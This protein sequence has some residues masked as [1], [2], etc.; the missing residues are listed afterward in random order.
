MLEDH[1]LDRSAFHLYTIYNLQEAS[2]TISAPSESVHFV[3]INDYEDDGG[4]LFTKHEPIE[5]ANGKLRSL[6]VMEFSIPELPSGKLLAI[7]ILSTWGDP[8]Y[9]GL[10]GIEIFD[11]FGH[12]VLLSNPEQQIWAN[13]PDIN[14][15]PEYSMS[16]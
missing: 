8:H 2:S 3:N 6:P 1:S 10:M 13:P 7:N 14:I 4:A 16:Q 9:V 12:P 11:N 15:L 5:L